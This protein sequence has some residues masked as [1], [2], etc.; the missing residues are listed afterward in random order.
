MNINTKLSKHNQL[1]LRKAIQS[2]DVYSYFNALTSEELFSRVESLLPEHRERL[3]P[4]T[5]VLAMFISQSLNADSSCQK[6]VNE[7]AVKRMAHGLPV[8]STATGGY[9]KARQRLPQQMVST[10]VR[11]SG[12]VMHERS[13]VQ[14]GWKGRAV[15]LI[16]GTTVSMPDTP[17]NQLAYPQQGSQKPGLGFPLCRLVGVICLSSGAVLDTAVGRFNGKGANEQALLRELLETFKTGDLVLG[18]SFYGTYFLLATMIEKGVDVV[19]EQQGARKRITD[20]RKG[21]RLGS[22]DHLIELAKPK[23]KPDWM[24]RS[25]YDQA[26]ETLTIRELLT[27]GK[28]IITT[29]LKPSEASKTDL[30]ILYKQRWQVELDFR[31]IKTTL[32]METLSCKTPEMNLKEMWVYFL[33]YNLIRLMM[34]QSALLVNTLPRALS[35]KHAL[36]LY[37]A[38]SQQPAFGDDPFDETILILIAQKTVGNRAGRVEPRAVK[39]RPKPFALLMKRRDLTREDIRKYGHPKKVK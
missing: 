20:F 3:F 23:I 11:Y 14:W 6:I 32:G 39:R 19:F 31:H 2:N 18:D 35:F 30:K 24:T 27:S 25:Y 37:I 34:A 9:C 12:Q 13:P 8:C 16:D 28:C 21:K 36:Q 29:I 5:E 26:P 38:W 7:M 1:I 17:E 15:K 22:K 10:L 33:A 4:P